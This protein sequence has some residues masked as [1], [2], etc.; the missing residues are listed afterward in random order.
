MIDASQLRM[1]TVHAHPDDEASKGS[2]LVARYVAEGVHATLVCCTGGELGSIINPAMDRPEVAANLA[3]V[4]REE[5]DRSAG[6]IGFQQVDLLG[7]RDSGMPDMP[8]NADPANFANAPLDEAVLTTLVS[9]YLTS[10]A[11]G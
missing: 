4:R 2:A 11:A 3:G 10:V 7:Y 9:E 8:E 1:L 6:I 5:L